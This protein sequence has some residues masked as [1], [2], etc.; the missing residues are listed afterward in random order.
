MLL[1]SLATI[2][3][4]VPVRAWNHPGT[5]LLLVQVA[6]P[7]GGKVSKFCVWGVPRVVRLTC[8]CTDGAASTNAARAARAFNTARE[9][10][11]GAVIIAGLISVLEQGTMSDGVRPESPGTV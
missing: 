2:V 10:D 4:P 5:V 11:F 7:L 3:V 8:A 6:D 1:P 9:R